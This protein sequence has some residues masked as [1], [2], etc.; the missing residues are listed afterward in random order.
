MEAFESAVWDDKQ[1]SFVI[2]AGGPEGRR[3]IVLLEP[4]G[5][6]CKPS[7]ASAFTKHRLSECESRA[8]VTLLL[9]L[10]ASLKQ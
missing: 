7:L 3:V 9:P 2:E 10:V 4:L 1:R 8:M 6:S 5:V